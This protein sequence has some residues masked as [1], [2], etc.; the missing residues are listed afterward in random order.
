MTYDQLFLAA[1]FVLFLV[2]FVATMLYV[3]RRGRDPKGVSGG[4]TGTAVINTVATLLWLA[5]ML[6]YI[7]DARSVV[8]FGRIAF[9]DNDVAKGLGIVLSTVGLLVGIAGEVTLGESFRVAL[10]RGET[11]LVTTGIYRYIRNPCAL[12]ADLFALGTF[13]IAPSLLALAAAVLNLAGYHLKIQAEE[14]YLRRAHR[15]DYTAYCARTGRYWPCLG[16][17]EKE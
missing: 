10:P 14:A 17:A 8:R 1:A 2:T 9:L 12:G 13:F 3:R 11:R 4:K 6:L 16:L 7:L 15:A 5:V